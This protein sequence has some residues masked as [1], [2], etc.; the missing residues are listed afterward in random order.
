MNRDSAYMVKLREGRAWTRD[1]FFGGRDGRFSPLYVP[2][3]TGDE[4][5]TLQDAIASY[6]DRV[7]A[8]HD[9]AGDGVVVEVDSEPI[10]VGGVDGELQ[11]LASS[12]FEEKADELLDRESGRTLYPFGRSW[13]WFRGD[14]GEAMARLSL[15]DRLSHTKAALKRS[16]LR[17]RSQIESRISRIWGDH[18]AAR[19]HRLMEP[20]IE[21]IREHEGL[22]G[23]R[24]MEILNSI[25]PIS[26]PK[27]YELG[28]RGKHML[29]NEIGDWY[30][31]ADLRI[32]WKAYSTPVDDSP[33]DGPL[34]LEIQ[35]KYLPI[36]FSASF[37]PGEFKD[38]AR[39]R[40]KVAFTWRMYLKE[41]SHRQ[42][43][44][45]DQLVQNVEGA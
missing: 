27:L 20:I 25:D 30:A 39:L 36:L 35:D 44:H 1:A 18:L 32:E 10:R 37:R 3:L 34:H 6:R 5:P 4:A 14:R 21:S 19:S 9:H 41:R 8:Q 11:K 45:L 13:C 31:P 38:L 22:Q 24:Q 29:A 23:A 7:Q 40:D 33:D 12:G 17:D 26:R 15:F 43:D 42:L 16:E 2:G 28:E